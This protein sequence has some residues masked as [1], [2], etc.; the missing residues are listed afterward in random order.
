MLHE[1]LKSAL[2]CHAAEFKTSQE[3]TNLTLWEAGSTLC[4]ITFK[5]ANELQLKGHPVKLEIVTIGGEKKL[6]DSAQYKLYILDEEGI[7]VEIEVLGINKISNVDTKVNLNYLPILYYVISQI[8]FK[9][10][11]RY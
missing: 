11:N 6:M 1:E 2:S 9:N 3:E 7:E 10:E 5:R 8:F 4:F